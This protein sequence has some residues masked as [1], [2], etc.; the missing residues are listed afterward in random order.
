MKSVRSVLVAS[1]ALALLAVPVTPAQAAPGEIVALGNGANANTL[2]SFSKEKPSI[3]TSIPVTGLGAAKLAGIDYRPATLELYGLGVAGNVVTQFTIQ[4]STGVATVVGSVDFSLLSGAT[5]SGATEFGV[6]LSPASDRL[7]VIDNLASDAGG[8]NVNNF[9]LNPS[10]GALAG[11]DPDLSFEA[12]PGGNTNAPMVA[13]AYSPKAFGSTATTLYGIVSGGDR[14]VIQGGFGGSPSPNGGILSDVGPLGVNTS[15]NAGFDVDSAARVAYAVLEVGGVSGLYAINL[16]TG[17]AAPIGTIGNG[18]VD[19]SGLT[20]EPP[21]LPV[22]TPT[23]TPT[24]TPQPPAPVPTLQALSVAPKAFAAA[25]GAK[26][27]ATTSAKKAPVGT[28]IGYTV[29]IAA[30]VTFSVERKTTGR[31]V[32]KTCKPRNRGNADHKRCPIW[33]TLK[34]GFSHAGAAGPNALRF[35]GKLSGKPL[36]PGNYKLLAQTGSSSLSTPFRIV[37]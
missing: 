24:P 30:T 10:S 26:A 33:R 18:S 17:A 27:K 16:A 20:V 32:G 13:I 19:F 4:P 37:P 21:P 28:T 29:S 1:L 15:N 14:L 11:N 23:P 8:G 6:S 35:N 31:K 25:G 9:R 22:S 36:S 34:A 7:R 12:L 5:I 2:F 3:V